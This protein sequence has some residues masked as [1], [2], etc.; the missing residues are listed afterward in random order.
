MSVQAVK[1]VEIGH[2][3]VAAGSFGSQVHDPI[4]YAPEDTGKPTR[5]TRASNN[6]GG[7]EGGISN[8]EDIVVRGYLKPISTLRKPLESVHF[9]TREATSASYERSD[10]CVVPAAG[11]VGE[12]M[13]ALTIARM[14]QE[15]FGGDSLIEL[16]RN[17][18]G[19]IEQIRSY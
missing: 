13:V 7:I 11:V 6:A 10:I 15:K 1:A 18:S 14:T 2:G 17:F 9:D 19:Y 8:G 4:Q 16:H 5:F 3:V 12:A